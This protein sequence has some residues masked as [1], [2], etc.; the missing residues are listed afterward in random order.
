MSS[1]I[2]SQGFRQAGYAGSRDVAEW[3]A[4]GVLIVAAAYALQLF[5]P[6]M[7][8]IELAPLE[9]VEGFTSQTSDANLWNQILWVGL[10][11]ISSLAVLRA[12]MRLTKYA[13][14]LWPLLAL[15]ALCILSAVWSDHPDAAIRR[16][17]QASLIFYC[18]LIGVVYS[19]SIDRIVSIF[20]LIFWGLLLFNLAALAR[21]WS[22]ELSGE[23]RGTFGHKNGAG[24][25]AAFALILGFSI[26]RGRQGLLNRLLC[27]FYLVAWGTLLV[28]SGSKTSLALIALVPI[29]FLLLR[30]GSKIL[31][32]NVGIVLIFGLSMV[33]SIIGLL[34][35]G[36][37]YTP[38][39]IVSQFIGDSS[40]TGRD[41]IW[42]FMLEHIQRSWLFGQGYGS[43][44]GVGFESPNLR[45]QFYFIRLLNQAHNG[46]L[47]LLVSVGAVGLTLFMLQ[48]LKAGVQSEAIHSRKPFLFQLI[49]TGII[50]SLIHN[51]TETSLLRGFSPVWIF[52][53]LALLL[54]A[55]ASVEARERT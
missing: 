29:L 14:A 21:P 55:R 45:S 33:A 27:G 12:P 13:A 34:V 25:I 31:R 5:S 6:H 38:A 54:A 23:F 47:D 17:T 19:T 48:L 30:A 4:D 11:A 15:L 53:L 7:T 3:I 18:F 32:L 2:H 52:T 26:I 40:F 9:E 37:G 16:S 51:I 20:Y 41:A 10:A 42:Q 44:W 28:L 8:P 36:G 50:F 46:Y 1:I 24:A 43:F 39:Y 35:Y 49:W 22:F